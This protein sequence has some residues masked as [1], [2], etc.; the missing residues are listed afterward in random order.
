MNT[1]DY[2][3]CPDN[4]T[5]LACRLLSTVGFQGN[6]SKDNPQIV[7]IN[8]GCLQTYAQ[9][10]L[11]GTKPPKIVIIVTNQKNVVEKKY[12]ALIK[13]N[14]LYPHVLQDKEEKELLLIYTAIRQRVTWSKNMR[15]EILLEVRDPFKKDDPIFPFDQTPLGQRRLP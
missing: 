6:L 1:L 3:V 11:G 10:I 5:E 2:G 13:E 7:F 4:I 8:L 9:K 15:G 12:E 14:K